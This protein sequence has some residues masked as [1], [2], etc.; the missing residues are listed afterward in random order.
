MYL[1]F[2]TFVTEYA[3]KIQHS[4]QN[5]LFLMHGNLYIGSGLLIYV[6]LTE[7][8]SSVHQLLYS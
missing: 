5:V 1:E 2:Y 7:F 8:V 4:K 3:S 6:F